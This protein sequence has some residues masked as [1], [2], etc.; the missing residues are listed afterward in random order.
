MSVKR[1]KVS[2]RIKSVELLFIAAAAMI[3]IAAIASASLNSMNSAL[4]SQTNYSSA[5]T[6][7]SKSNRQEPADSAYSKL[8]QVQIKLKF[9]DKTETIGHELLSEIV[10]EEKNTVDVNEDLLREYVTK[11]GKKYSTYSDY[12]PFKTTDGETIHLRNNSMGWILDED[13]AYD[14]LR[15]MIMKMKSVSLDLTDRSEESDKWWM[16]ITADYNTGKNN[17][18]TYAEVSIDQQHMWVYKDSKLVL[19]SDVVTGL[20]ED[21]RDTPTGAFVIGYKQK[22]ANL[23]DTDYLIRVKY[24]ISFNN[25]V[26]FHDAE[27]Q[28]YFGGDVYTY[29][30]SHGCVNMPLDAVSKLYDITYEN[31]PVYVY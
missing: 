30:G 21:G 10:K 24:W 2:R 22:D 18:K 25:D 4:N 3:V 1:K 27:W 8:M 19:E 20:P 23:Y 31:M 6:K 15:S 7:S 5:L 17:N 26:G 16:R 13:Y 12:I 29:N 11:L 28:D 9:G 14:E